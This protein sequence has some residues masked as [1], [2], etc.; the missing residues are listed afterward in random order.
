MKRLTAITMGLALG[1][2]S[3]QDVRAHAA[4][5]AAGFATFPASLGYGALC[6]G[7]SGYM[8]RDLFTEVSQ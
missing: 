7:I 2:C 5:L 6:A 3:A 1:A 4:D 8:D